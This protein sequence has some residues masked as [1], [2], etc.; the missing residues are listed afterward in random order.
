M[1]ITYIDQPALRLITVK[2]ESCPAGIPASWQSL[3]T[4]RDTKGRKSYGVIC[5]SPE[6]P[7]YYAGLF[8]DGEEEER[9]T[10]MPVLEVAGGPCARVKLMDWRQHIPEIAPLFAQLMEAVDQDT[11]RPNME[12][13]RSSTEL[14]LLVPVKAKAKE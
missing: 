1:N 13:Y 10:G 3:E 8:S 6:G 9:T 5:G 4:K 7:V 11:S 12:F 2:A 14:H